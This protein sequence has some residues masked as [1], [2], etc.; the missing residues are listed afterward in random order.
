LIIQLAIY[1]A[2]SDHL[3][4]LIFITIPT[5]CQVAADRDVVSIPGEHPEGGEVLCDSPIFI[6]GE[7]YNEEE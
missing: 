7:S 4:L 6:R 2:V 3:S 5:G 1:G